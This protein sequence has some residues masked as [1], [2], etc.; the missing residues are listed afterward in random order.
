MRPLSCSRVCDV[1]AG[2][3]A[4][5]VVVSI[6]LPAF[7]SDDSEGNK[8]PATSKC[9]A[10]APINGPCNSGYSTCCCRIS[11]STVYTCEC[12]LATVCQTPGS[13]NHCDDGYSAPD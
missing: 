12:R 3:A 2:L 7:A 4:V 11:P 6:T 5:T 1:L 8:C 13:G 9:G 10:V